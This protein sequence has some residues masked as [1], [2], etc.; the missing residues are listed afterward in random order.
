MLPSTPH[1]VPA[2]RVQQWTDRQAAAQP[3][4]LPPAEQQLS[5]P[6]SSPAPFIPVDDRPD[7]VA[8]YLDRYNAPANY[9]HRNHGAPMNSDVYGHP[10]W[11]CPLVEMNVRR[12]YEEFFLH[13]DHQIDHVDQSWSRHDVLQLLQD[14]IAQG[15]FILP[16]VD[17]DM[18]ENLCTGN[19]GV[20]R[21]YQLGH[22]PYPF[23]GGAREELP[24]IAAFP[25]RRCWSCAR[26]QHPIPSP[27]VS[28]DGIGEDDSRDNRAI[29]PLPPPSLDFGGLGVT[30]PFASPA[31]LALA[32]DVDESDSDVDN[33]RS[34]LAGDEQDGVIDQ[35]RAAL[36]ENVVD[37]E[38]VERDEGY[39][40]LDFE[41]HPRGLAPLRSSPAQD[42][43]VHVV[44]QVCG[45]AVAEGTERSALVVDGHS[46]PSPA[47]LVLSQSSSSGNTSSAEGSLSNR[48]GGSKRPI[49][50]DDSDLD[51]ENAPGPSTKK[52]AR[53]DWSY[54]RRSLS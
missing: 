54:G 31:T 30:S 51:Q 16:D 15:L 11:M 1:I 2:A 6:T 34:A 12:R 10:L 45:A 40:P 52:K 9:P 26:L 28:D 46:Q 20:E 17:V 19:F 41:D 43:S 13:L 29:S 24:G 47:P 42:R 44:D 3:A 39:P 32:L 21:C 5:S 22:S 37:A 14:V 23:R 7:R 50:V 36:T 18:R 53:I 25:C 48:P 35:V 8:V 49:T 33:A 27:V 38:R 4:Y